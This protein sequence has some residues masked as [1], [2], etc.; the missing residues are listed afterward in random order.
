MNRA[1]VALVDQQVNQFGDTLLREATMKNESAYRQAE[2]K[3]R[4]LAEQAQV[5]RYQAQQEHWNQMEKQQGNTAAKSEANTAALLQQ[6]QGEQAQAGNQQELQNKQRMFQ[7]ALSLNSSGGLSDDARNDFNDW[8][9]DDEHFGPTGIQIS[10]PDP[11][12]LPKGAAGIRHSAAVDALNQAQG[13][14]SQAALL[15]D[16]DPDKDQFNSYAEMLENAARKAG[17]GP[18]ARPAET[19][20]IKRDAMGREIERTRAPV[21][22][23]GSGAGAAPPVGVLHPDGRTTGTVPADQLQAAIAQGYK[24]LTPDAGSGD[25]TGG[26]QPNLAQ[27]LQQAQLQ[28][29]LNPAGLPVPNLGPGGGMT[30][31]AAQQPPTS[32]Y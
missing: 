1:D 28:R 26:G 31:P 29:A 23:S 15:D 2:L 17:S 5:Q 16:G 25:G 18:Q 13:Y 8:L 20:T 30:V 7:N 24:A 19:T 32:P 6:R 9:S 3:Y 14:R 21:G 12:M 4:Q 27:M 10:K 22:G 11:S